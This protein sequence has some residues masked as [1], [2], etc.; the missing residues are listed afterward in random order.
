MIPLDRIARF[1]LPICTAGGKRRN[2]WNGNS[3]PLEVGS[4][5]MGY[6]NAGSDKITV[7]GVADCVFWEEGG[8][9]I[10][11]YKT[12]V[13]SCAEELADKYREQLRIYR[14]ILRQSLQTEVKACILYSFHLEKEIQLDF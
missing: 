12:D 4:E 13:V 9:V 3:L 2:A 1:F 14:M 5:W 10:V 11:D 7:Q 8:M 6:E